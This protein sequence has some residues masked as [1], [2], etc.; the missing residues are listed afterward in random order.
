MLSG[1]WNHQVVPTFSYVQPS[2]TPR[3]KPAGSVKYEKLGTS[4]HPLTSRL[5]P[6]CGVRGASAAGIRSHTSGLN[7]PGPAVDGDGT[8]GAA[9]TGP[10]VR[11][12]SCCTR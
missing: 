11:S 5:A 4:A 3:W 6:G 9:P 7:P 1:S 8:M 2:G 12:P 10:P